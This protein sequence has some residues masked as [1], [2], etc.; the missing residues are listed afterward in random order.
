MEENKSIRRNKERR[1]KN[2]EQ[3]LVAAV[4]GSKVEVSVVDIRKKGLLT[5]L[6]DRA[7]RK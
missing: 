2:L 5:V 6:R 1:L 3:E 7:R 4:R